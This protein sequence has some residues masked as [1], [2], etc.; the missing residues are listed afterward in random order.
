MTYLIENVLF[1]TTH[2][3]FACYKFIQNIGPV[4]VKWKILRRKDIPIFKAYVFILEYV[5]VDV[6]PGVGWRVL[7]EVCHP[8]RQPQVQQVGLH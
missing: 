1:I 8:A 5:I 4:L 3:L 2:V 7:A 6:L